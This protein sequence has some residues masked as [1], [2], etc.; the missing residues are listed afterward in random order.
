MYNSSRRASIGEILVEERGSKEDSRIR[1]RS[2]RDECFN[3][4][5]SALMLESV[6]S[7][8]V[9]IPVVSTENVNLVDLLT[10]ILMISDFCLKIR[11]H[12][13]D[14]INSEPTNAFD[15]QS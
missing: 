6:T 14:L 15:Y 2:S 13:R 7:I 8:A 10:I 9:Q 12:L 5:N 3:W 11:L 4:S 1:V